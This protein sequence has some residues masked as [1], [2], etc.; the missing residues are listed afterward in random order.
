MI[1]GVS[2]ALMTGA[3]G[4]GQIIGP[5]FAGLVVG[6]AGQLRRALGAAVV[7]LLGAAGLVLKRDS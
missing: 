3:F 7:A 1:R 6:A 5:T 4:L 2:L